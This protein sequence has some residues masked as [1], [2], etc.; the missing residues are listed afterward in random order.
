LIQ[1]TVKG[2]KEIQINVNVKFKH[3]SKTQ[4]ERAEQI[5]TGTPTFRVAQTQLP[6]GLVPLGGPMLLMQSQNTRM[7]SAISASHQQTHQQSGGVGVGDFRI[8]AVVENIGELEFE[9][10]VQRR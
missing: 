1:A 2:I 4:G 10:P 3:K 6:F 7:S 8:D 9:A 5:I